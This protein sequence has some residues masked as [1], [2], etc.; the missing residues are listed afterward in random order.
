[1]QSYP[2]VLKDYFSALCGGFGVFSQPLS[3]IGP[4]QPGLSIISRVYLED[5]MG[6]GAVKNL[7]VGQESGVALIRS[8]HFQSYGQV[9]ILSFEERVASL[10]EEAC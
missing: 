7:I 3:Q 2:V 9:R 10:G 6:Q 5:K 1:M 4:Q 8:T